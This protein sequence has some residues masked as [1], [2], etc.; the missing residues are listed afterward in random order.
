[1]T[2]LSKIDLKQVVLLNQDGSCPNG[3]DPKTLVDAGY[4][5]VQPHEPPRATGL[6]AYETEPL[7]IDGLWHQTWQLTMCEECDVV[8]PE[9]NAINQQQEL[10]DLFLLLGIDTEEKQAAFLT[11]LEMKR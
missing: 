10:D 3:L 6:V 8:L 4:R 1:M 2:S 5:L 7:L 9:Q 11:L